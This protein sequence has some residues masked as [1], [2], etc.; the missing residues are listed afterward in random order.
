MRTRPR[1]VLPLLAAC[2]VAFGAAT[3][4]TDPA[5]L[6]G[7]PARIADPRSASA[8]AAWG[9]PL[10]VEQFDGKGVD[11]RNWWVYDSPNAAAFPRSAARATVAGGTLRLTGGFDAAGRD[12]SGGIASKTDLRYG[13]WEVRVR[14]ERGDGYSGVVLLWPASGHWPTDGEIDLL[15]AINGNRQGASSF[16]HNGSNNHVEWH[17]LPGDYSQWHTIAVEWLP[18]SITFYLNGVPEWTVSAPSTAGAFN[19]IPS[20]SAMHLALQLDKGCISVIPC[21]TSQTPATVTMYVDQVRI[22]AAPRQLT[23]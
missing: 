8:V 18:R 17:Y 12:L 16:V 10:F 6:G 1:V 19:P 13:R 11:P 2:V 14:V 5:V 9:A 15:E 23:G 22:W 7:G 3:A 21:R 4:C 20:T